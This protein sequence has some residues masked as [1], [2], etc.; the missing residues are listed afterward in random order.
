MKIY[1]IHLNSCFRLKQTRSPIIV[2]P[3]IYVSLRLLRSSLLAFTTVIVLISTTATA[4]SVINGE[5]IRYQQQRMVFLQWDQNKFTPKP[6]F[7][8]LNPY[9]WLTW[10]LFY[11]SYHKNDLRPLSASG[12]QTQRLAL[13][14]TMNSIDGKYKLQSDTVRNT[15]LSA[16]AA[17][18]GALSDAEPLWLLYYKKQFQP[19]LN[20]SAANIL[21]PLPHDVGEK[22]V[23]E[24]LYDWYSNELARLK[25]RV[26]GARSAN[27]DRG[28]RILSYYRLLNEYKRISSVWAIRT[29][30][31]AITLRITARRQQ[32]VNYQ[33]DIPLWTPQ[34]D[35]QIVNRVL[36]HLQ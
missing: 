23:A 31:A 30:S 21:G 5:S 14:G 19:L 2:W 8:S 25:E 11:P 27:M 17:Q 7:L 35:I 12:A 18:S 10:G 34:S 33:S 3:V 28:S 24:G 29:A 36:N 4:Q 26:Q 9:Y 16:I 22:L 1:L 20:Y 15:M 13:A 32:L 6:G